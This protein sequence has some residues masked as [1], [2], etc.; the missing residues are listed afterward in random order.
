M[1][2]IIDQLVALVDNFDLAALFP[3]M[4]SVIGWAAAVARLCILAAPLIML[5]LG[6]WYRFAPP[7]KANHAVGYRFYY[8]MGSQQAWRYTQQLAG[9]IWTI[10]G[11]ALAVIMLIISLFFGAMDAMDMASTAVACIIWEVV[12]I[13]ASCVAINVLVSK[14]F[15]KDGNPRR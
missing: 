15:D 3:K 7:K 12:L 1:E 10:L 4:D 9:R 14:K 6:L 11:G 13:V 2:N 5:G 8:G